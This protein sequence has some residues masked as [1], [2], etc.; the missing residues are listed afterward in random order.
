MRHWN[1]INKVKG[2]PSRNFYQQA[3]EKIK[4]LIHT[5]NIKMNGS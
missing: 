1:Y 2:K 4:L 5:N 3:K